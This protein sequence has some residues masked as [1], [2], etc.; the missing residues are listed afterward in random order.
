MVE[1]AIQLQFSGNLVLA[2][3]EG[4]SPLHGLAEIEL[5]D[6][7]LTLFCD[8]E[9]AA[10]KVVPAPVRKTV[11]TLYSTGPNERRSFFAKCCGALL[12]VRQNHVQVLLPV[13][14]EE[15]DLE[16][17]DAGV[18]VIAE[19]VRAARPSGRESHR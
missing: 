13:R 5:Q 15:L 1:S 9:K 19:L 17:L 3:P 12:V 7:G 2:P 14:A 18:E 11:R 16:L 10:R 6:E 8:D 4:R